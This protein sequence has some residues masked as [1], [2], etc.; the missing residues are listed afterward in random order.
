MAQQLR[1][2]AGTFDY[3]N[4]I[5][6]T[7][8]P[9]QVGIVAVVAGQE[10]LLRGTVLGKDA[11]GKYAVAN[12]TATPAITGTVILTDTVATGSGSGT[13]INAQV[14][15]SGAFNRSALILGGTDTITDHE[16]TLKINGIYLKSTI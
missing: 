14:Y 1:N 15:V 13:A 5:P 4:L 3:D 16:E 2:L 6:D 8:F 11:E 10:N 9:V 12:K 7:S